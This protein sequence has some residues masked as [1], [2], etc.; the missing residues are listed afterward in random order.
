MM[1]PLQ[2]YMLQNGQ[3]PRGAGGMPTTPEGPGVADPFTQ[4][5]DAA[6]MMDPEDGMDEFGQRRRPRPYMT[7]VPT[8]G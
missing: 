4:G 7:A 5:D 6:P 1:S 8:Q 3:G 2:R